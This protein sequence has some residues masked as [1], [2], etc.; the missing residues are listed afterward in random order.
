MK[1]KWRTWKR[2]FRDFRIFFCVNCKFVFWKWLFVARCP[3][4]FLNKNVQLRHSWGMN[5]SPS[6]CQI[7]WGKLKVEE[8][9]DR[10][11]GYLKTLYYFVHLDQCYLVMWGEFLKEMHVLLNDLTNM[12]GT[13]KKN[14]SSECQ[15]GLRKRKLEQ[16]SLPNRFWL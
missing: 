8:A 4:N 9:V 5:T 15:A 11:A 1:V 2:I 6:T 16:T 13:V 12:W 7:V 3:V 14:Q 10:N